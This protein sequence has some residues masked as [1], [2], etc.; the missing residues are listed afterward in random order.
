MK[1]NCKHCN[2]STDNKTSYLKHVE[3][4]KHRKKAGLTIK[5]DELK[6][7]VKNQN[8]I[9]EEKNKLLEEKE[10]RLQKALREVGYLKNIITNYTKCMYGGYSDSEDS[11]SDDNTTITYIIKNHPYP[12]PTDSD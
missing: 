4:N 7:E 9:I 8:K 3:T 10:E 2:I 5:E 11:D 6:A 12:K 1:F